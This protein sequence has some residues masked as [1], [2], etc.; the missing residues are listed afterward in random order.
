VDTRDLEA[1]EV[2]LRLLDI[3][4]RQVTTMRKEL[5]GIEGE[6]TLDIGQLDPGVY[7]LE[8]QNREFRHTVKWIKQ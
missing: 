4:G 1:G 2:T 7:F 3:Q 5:A 6:L 8:L